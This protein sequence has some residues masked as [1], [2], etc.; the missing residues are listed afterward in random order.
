MRNVLRAIGAFI[1]KIKIWNAAA[2]LVTLVLLFV[3]GVCTILL[4]KGKVSLP[5]Q[6]QAKRW[7][8]EVPCAQISYFFS[9]EV[10]L[11]AESIE[12][13]RYSLEQELKTRGY[14]AENAG[15]RVFV[16]AY[17]AVREITVSGEKKSLSV[18][19]IGAGGEF[20]L[21]HPVPLLCGNYFSEDT[22]REDV[23]L[24]DEEIAWHLYG[25][26]DIAGKDVY[27]NG[28]PYSII[29]V[30]ER[31]SGELETAAGSDKATLYLPF[32]AFEELGDG[33]IT[34]YEIVLPNPVKG[35]GVEVISPHFTYETGMH[36]VENSA[37]FDYPALYE[38]WKNRGIRTMKTDDI[39]L[40][41]WENLARVKEEELMEYALVQ[42]CLLAVVVLYWICAAITFMV[43]HKP[44][45]AD[46]IRW[47]EWG[48]E[49]VIGKIRPIK[50]KK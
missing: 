36:M 44:T 49:K 24:I 20:F 32:A 31:Q 11:T 12:F 23:V 21:F 41:F 30:F 45:K 26:P 9:K 46:L 10:G 34:N 22:V 3:A 8:T 27:I 25:S 14:V 38:V 16:D 50:D 2:I 4:E 29:G 17:S 1:V 7:E 48:Q 37:R 42:V 6:L 33:V 43:R 18:D 39:V 5:D 47:M 13:T 40:P 28:T 35:Y 15:A 19:A